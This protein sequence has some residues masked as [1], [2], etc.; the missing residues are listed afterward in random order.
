MD[1]RQQKTKPKKKKKIDDYKQEM[2]RTDTR[3]ID[4]K[5]N[6]Q[7]IDDYKQEMYRTDTRT[8]DYKQNKQTIDD[9]KQEMYRTDTRT[10]DWVCLYELSRMRS[11]ML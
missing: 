5:Q 8:I 6:K 7:T 3:T 10:I 2:Y 1:C 11:G 4:Y 9:Y